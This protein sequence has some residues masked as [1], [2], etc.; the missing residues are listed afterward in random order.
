MT[1]VFI[2]VA[3]DLNNGIGYNGKL[4]WHLPKDLAYFQK[5]TTQTKDSTKKNMVVMGRTT[6]E[7]LPE[8]ARPLSGR[9]NVVLTHSKTYKARGAFVVRSLWHALFHC[10]LLDVEN[11]FIIGGSR[12]FQEA[13]KNNFADA[14]YLTRILRV[15]ECDTFF[16][17]ISKE[18]A[19]KEKIGEGSDE[20]VKFE[21]WKWEK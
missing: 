20:G 13:L 5:I 6:W 17:E 19:I 4:P 14:I 7:S 21:F 8:N 10:Y 9:V 16:P 12:V 2:I 11:M 3:V 15:Y 1:P 18:F